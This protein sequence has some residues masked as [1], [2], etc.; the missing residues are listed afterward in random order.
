MTAECFRVEVPEHVRVAGFTATGQWV[1]VVPG[2]HVVHRLKPKVPLH[3]VLDTLRFLGA[4]E[5]GRDVHVPVTE[6]G[7]LR[8]VL[9]GGA[10]SSGIF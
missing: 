10:P 2:E 5:W 8:K 6:E 1:P 3:G 9:G 4:D 7:D